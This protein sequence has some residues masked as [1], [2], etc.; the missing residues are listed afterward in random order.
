MI[1]TLDYLKSNYRKGVERFL[2]N[3]EELTGLKSVNKAPL[4]SEDK[5]VLLFEVIL[6]IVFIAWVAPILFKLCVDIQLLR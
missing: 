1:K 2:T 4:N 5:F 6:F 3:I